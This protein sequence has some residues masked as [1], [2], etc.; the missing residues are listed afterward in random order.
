MRY[1]IIYKPY[2]MLCQFSKE[3]DKETLADLPFDFPKDIYPVGRLDTDSEGLLILTNDKKLN[4]KLLN[5]QFAH[6]RT[7]YVQV[8]GQIHKAAIQHLEEGITI[9]VK[10]KDYFTKPAKAEI[11]SE[12]NLPPRNPPVRY[13]A[14]IPTSWISLTLTEGKNRQVRHMT[15]AVKFPTL[16]LVRFA[17]EG[18]ELGEMQSGDIIELSGTELYEKLGMKS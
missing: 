14:S 8:D 16:R 4:H 13:R 3:G 17:I 15:A 18:I 11:I 6:K 10:K 9:R 2:Q 12:P 1:F 7:Y 5:P